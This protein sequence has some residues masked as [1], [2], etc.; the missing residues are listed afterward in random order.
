[1]SLWEGYFDTGLERV[2]LLWGTLH[3]EIAGSTFVAW[4][5]SPLEVEEG[6]GIE[7]GG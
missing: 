4:R 2:A 3:L 7:S 6:W 5:N 1:M